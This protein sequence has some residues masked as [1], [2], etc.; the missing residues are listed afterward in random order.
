MAVQTH[1]AQ[2]I[3]KWQRCSSTKH[4]GSETCQTTLSTIISLFHLHLGIF[5]F[6]QGSAQPLTLCT[7]VTCTAP[8]PFAS[9][10]FAINSA[11]ATLRCVPATEQVC[12]T[13]F[14][15]PEF[16]KWNTVLSTICSLQTAC[17][18]VHSNIV[19]RLVPTSQPWHLAASSHHLGSAGSRLSSALKPEA[20]CQFM[21]CRVMPGVRS[22]G[23]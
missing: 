11:A 15:A 10:A 7:C 12:T 22:G 8:T 5:H 20:G 19:Q 18:Q 23:V 13:A 16:S 6:H 14:R 3:K 9:N 1:T 17:Q 2:E 21:Q 4:Y